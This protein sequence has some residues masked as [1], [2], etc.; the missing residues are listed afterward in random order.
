MINYE[1]DKALVLRQANM[2]LGGGSLRQIANATGVSHVTVKRNFDVKLQYYNLETYYK[3]Q[4]KLIDNRP[5]T[6]DDEKVIKRVMEAYELL[7]NQDKTVI[8]IADSL[9]TT[10]FTIYRDL[11]KRLA[12]LKEIAPKLVTEEMLVNVSEALSRH[13]VNNSPMIK[14]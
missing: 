9:G 8:E 6:I 2:Y 13:S 4:E 12:M 3:V 10:P 5:A 11:T 14:K 7:V 1:E